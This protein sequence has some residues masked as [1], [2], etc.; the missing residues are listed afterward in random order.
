MLSLA[1]SLEAKD[2]DE[3]CLRKQ[4]IGI[5]H[6]RK[7]KKTPHTKASKKKKSQA[8]KKEEINKTA[9]ENTG[10]F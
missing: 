2:L 5:W 1:A 10:K 9:D 3:F 4:D 8:E 7:K 6:S